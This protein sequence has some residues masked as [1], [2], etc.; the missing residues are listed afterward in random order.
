M[1]AEFSSWISVAG[2]EG[3]HKSSKGTIS[4]SLCRKGSGK[5]R[6]IK[7]FYLYFL[8]SLSHQRYKQRGRGNQEIN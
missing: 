2:G 5:I 3:R 4:W 1:A 8:L 7:S 6:G